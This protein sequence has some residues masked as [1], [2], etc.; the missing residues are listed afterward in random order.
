MHSGPV[1]DADWSPAQDGVFSTTGTEGCV[2]LY[3]VG[4]AGAVKEPRRLMGH[5]GDVNSVRFD[6]SGALLATGGDDRVVRVWSRDSGE[7]VQELRDHQ[8][9]VTVV[10]WTTADAA[11]SSS[12]SSSGSALLASASLD[13]TIRVYDA[14]TSKTL[15]V[16]ARHAHPVTSLSFQ[17]GAGGLLVSGSHDRVHLWS[18]ADGALVKT[19]RSEGEGGVNDLAWDASGR[20]I[21][22]AY[23]D[24]WNYLLDLKS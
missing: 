6:S 21:V 16:L 7:C 11:L 23:A 5:V 3:A 9:E 4:A 10:R 15:H 18:V 14:S 20:R 17:S 19:F 13:C 24:S 12:S 22:V 8:R 2:F 1:I